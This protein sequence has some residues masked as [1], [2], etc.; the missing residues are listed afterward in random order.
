VLLQNDILKEFVASGT[1]I[2]P[3]KPSVKLV[4]DT[5]EYCAHNFPTRLPLMVCGSHMRHAGGKVKHGP[6]FAFADAIAY[7]DEA[8]GRGLKLESFAPTLTFHFLIH[9]DYFEEI[10]KF[11]TA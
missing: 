11:R 8:L 7:V 1:Y 9:K 10:A 6:S 3:P 5:L 2:F 4:I